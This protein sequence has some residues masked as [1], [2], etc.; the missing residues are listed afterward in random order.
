MEED[1]IYTARNQMSLLLLICSTICLSIELKVSFINHGENLNTNWL[2]QVVANTK[3]SLVLDVH[4]FISVHNSFVF[5]LHI[6][7]MLSHD[8]FTFFR[9][10]WNLNMIMWF[11][12]QGM[13]TIFSS[14]L[15]SMLLRFKDMF[16]DMHLLLIYNHSW[17]LASSQLTCGFMPS[18]YNVQLQEFTLIIHL[19][20]LAP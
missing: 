1:I 5:Y 13:S 6:T 10:Y 14:I 16:N 7:Q 4:F 17:L 2:A 18:S 15:V 20:P 19:L 3:T 12:H 11:S 8:F 9:I